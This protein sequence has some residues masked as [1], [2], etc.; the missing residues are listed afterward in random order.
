[1]SLKQQC[2]NMTQAKKHI[3]NLINTLPIDQNIEH[4]HIKDLLK[5]HPTKKI[6]INNVE[7]IK[8]KIRPPY[9]NRALF[10][11]YKNSN[12]EDDIS[13]KLCIRHFYGRYCQYKE[14]IKDVKT[15][16]RNEVHNGTKK[17]YFINNTTIENNKYTG[18]CN[19][20][21]MITE[22]ITTDHFKLSYKEIFDNFI[23][24]NNIDL[25]H[26]TI[27]ENDNNEIR[28]KNTNLALKWLNYHDT[29]A[30]Y[31]LLCSSCNSH[32][33]CYGYKS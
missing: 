26:I 19:N 16:F 8:I 14:H 21:N 4:K 5:Y 7:W 12:D 17:E 30:H 27:F 9:N 23:E 29:K 1:M 11:K 13:W 31:R 24:L 22:D 32:F 10:Y 25:Q 15:A 2:Q 33:G 3:S 6:D 18:K 28:I 20:C